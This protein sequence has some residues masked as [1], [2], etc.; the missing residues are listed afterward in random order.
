M[1]TY[2]STCIHRPIQHLGTK[3]GSPAYKQQKCTSY[4]SH[5]ASIAPPPTPPSRG[6]GGPPPLAPFSGGGPPTG[7][8]CL[9]SKHPLVIAAS[10]AARRTMARHGG[11]T[12][13][14]CSRKLSS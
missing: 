7:P 5:G 13:T 1:F 14:H 6:G 3:T 8:S 2:K 4:I 10:T 9:G 12:P 11:G